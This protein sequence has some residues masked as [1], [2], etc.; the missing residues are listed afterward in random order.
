LAPEFG[1]GEI[2]YKFDIYSLGVLIME[3][4]TGKRGYNPV[5]M[6]ITIKVFYRI[7]H[8]KTNALLLLLDIIVSLNNIS[9]K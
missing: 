7:L 8:F 4:L 2:T 6:V 5:D 9:N 3:I 1:N